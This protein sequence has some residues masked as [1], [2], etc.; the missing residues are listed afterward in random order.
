[1]LKNKTYRIISLLVV[2]AMG[3]AMSSSILF[4][5]HSTTKKIEASKTKTEQKNQD[6]TSISSFSEATFSV[7]NFSFTASLI[8]LFT[9]VVIARYYRIQFVYLVERVKISYWS[10]LYS[11]TIIVNAP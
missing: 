9:L 10:N 8:F 7:V 1:M 3:F 5:K 11:S 2:L 6:E 4:S